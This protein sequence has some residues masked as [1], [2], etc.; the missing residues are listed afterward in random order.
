M[1]NMM[2]KIN[3]FLWN[4]PRATIY[5]LGILTGLLMAFIF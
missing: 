1:S 2:E 5:I 4:Y 3:E